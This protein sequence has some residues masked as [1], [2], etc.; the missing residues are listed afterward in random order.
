MQNYENNGMCGTIVVFSLFNTLD[1]MSESRWHSSGSLTPLLLIDYLRRIYSY[2]LEP[3]PRIL[4]DCQQAGPCPGT[5]ASADQCC[6]RPPCQTLRLLLLIW[7]EE[8]LS[9]AWRCLHLGQLEG[10]DKTNLVG[11]PGLQFHK[12][13]GSFVGV[14]MATL[15]WLIVSGSTWR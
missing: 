14:D 6:S 7:L 10:T 13:M 11:E 9:A 3:A 12:T 15:L 5:R 8:P 2:R 1:S 4:S